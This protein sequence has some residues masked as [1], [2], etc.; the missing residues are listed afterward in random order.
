MLFPTLLF[1]FDQVVGGVEVVT[2]RDEV[3]D[4][5]IIWIDGE[6]IVTFLIV[7]LSPL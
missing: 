6:N 7:E 3:K 4:D 1:P 2:S 5:G